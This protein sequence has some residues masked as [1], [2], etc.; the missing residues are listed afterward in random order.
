MVNSP[1]LATRMAFTYFPTGGP[2]L[3]HIFHSLEFGFYF[4]PFPSIKEEIFEIFLNF[5]RC[6]S[7]QAQWEQ[8]KPDQSPHHIGHNIP[9]REHPGTQTEK[10]GHR[11][12]KQRQQHVDAHFPAG[13]RNGEQEQHHGD[14]G[15]EQQ[16]QDRTEQRQPQPSPQQAKQVI[17]ETDSKSQHHRSG[18]GGCLLRN[19]DRHLSAAAG[20]GNRPSPGPR[21]HT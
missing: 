5:F 4:K 21:P 6:A 14:R 2:K 3:G 17:Q 19:G 11:S 10:I 12:A 18:K 15:P 16:V 7:Q 9:Q 8:Q 20:P 1:A 13:G